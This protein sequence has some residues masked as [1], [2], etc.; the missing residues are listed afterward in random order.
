[1]SLLLGRR[2]KW[3]PDNKWTRQSSVIY[4]CKFALHITSRSCNTGFLYGTVYSYQ[5]DL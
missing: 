4:S 3:L 2:F 5:V 1:M